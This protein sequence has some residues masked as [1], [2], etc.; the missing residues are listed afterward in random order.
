MHCLQLEC[1]YRISNDLFSVTGAIMISR[2]I[3]YVTQDNSNWDCCVDIFATL[4]DNH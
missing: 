1:I 3:Q 4:P 2:L